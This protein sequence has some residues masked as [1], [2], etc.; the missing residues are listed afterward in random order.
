M[1]RVPPVR[2]AIGKH[3]WTLCPERRTPNRAEH[4][5]RAAFRSA[6]SVMV[7]IPLCVT[8]T[9]DGRARCSHRLCGAAYEDEPS[10]ARSRAAHNRVP[11]PRRPFHRQ[12]A[13]F[14][15]GGVG[16]VDS[17]RTGA[18][19]EQ[20]RIRFFGPNKRRRILGRFH[21]GGVIRHWF[22]RPISGV[23]HHGAHLV[24]PPPRAGATVVARIGATAGFGL[25]QFNF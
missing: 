1:R 5:T 15:L 14:D 25:F 22:R 7:R 24:E 23:V 21:G 11:G 20:G 18:D 4:R 16:A 13:S 19:F 3:R 8:Q 10:T 6:A 17:T 2:E 9:C 12:L